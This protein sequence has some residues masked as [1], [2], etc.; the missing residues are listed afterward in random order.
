MELNQSLPLVRRLKTAQHR[1]NTFGIE[2]DD[3]DYKLGETAQTLWP[4]GMA[5]NART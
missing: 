4:R 2:Q 5:I 3:L 1:L